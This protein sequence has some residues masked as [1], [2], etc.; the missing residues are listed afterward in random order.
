MSEIKDFTAK[1]AANW[2]K[3]EAAKHTTPASRQ[4]RIAGEIKFMEMM[5]SM[6]GRF[7]VS[8]AAHEGLIAVLRENA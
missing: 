8:D 2:I 1:Q 4:E 5:K 7:P 3:Q 6:R